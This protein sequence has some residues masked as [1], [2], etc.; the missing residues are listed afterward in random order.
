M[1]TITLNTISF[2]LYK[3]CFAGFSAQVHAGDRIGIIGNNGT[4]K[5]T[6]LRVLMG[7]LLPTSGEVVLPQGLA[8]AH[9]PQLITDYPHLSGAQR[10]QKCFSE[11]VAQHPDVLVL[12]EPTNH[13]DTDNRTSLI[14][15]LQHFKGILFMATHDT[16]PFG[17]WKR[18]RCISFMAAMGIMNKNVL[19]STSNILQ[20]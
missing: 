7:D 11:A 2:E 14:R 5:T 12:D 1:S 10:F 16:E 13:L 20:D 9:V 18:A 3:T 6:L 8:I 17:I 4:G 15:F 19:S